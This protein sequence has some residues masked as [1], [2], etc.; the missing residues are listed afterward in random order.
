MIL[1]LLFTTFEIVL[2]AAPIVPSDFQV[3]LAIIL[4][5]IISH[6]LK[7]QTAYLKIKNTWLQKEKEQMKQIDTIDE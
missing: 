5:Y 3:R 6:K 2:F 1:D 4:L 7:V